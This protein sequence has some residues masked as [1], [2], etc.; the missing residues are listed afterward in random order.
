MNNQLERA[1]RGF[2]FGKFYPLHQG[3]EALI[4]Y[5]AERCEELIVVVCVSNRELLSVAARV[6]WVQESCR[7]LPQV[8]VRGFE[9]REEE[10]PNSSV[11]DRAISKVWAEKFLQILPPLQVVFTGEEYGDFV[12][13]YMG[14]RHERLYSPGRISASMIRTDPQSYWGHLSSAARESLLAKVAILGTESTGKSTLTE[15]LAQHYQTEYVREVGREVVPKS[16]A[17]TWEDLTAIA[18]QH[19]ELIRRQASLARRVLFLDT[20]CHITQSYGELLFG[21]TLPLSQGVITANAAQLYL[22]LAADAPF[23]QDGTRLS[24]SE[25]SKL[26]ESHRAVLDRAGIR[27]HVLRGSWEEKYRAAVALI[28]QSISWMAVAGRAVAA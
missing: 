1:K 7:H 21:R 12:A 8:I 23:V 16:A 3:H 22:Y 11:S 10:L 28:D 5:G 26:D 25:R 27:Y 18:E 2:V 17:C 13:E 6:K 19:A 20:D 24:L 14:I 15:F 9:Y 4:R